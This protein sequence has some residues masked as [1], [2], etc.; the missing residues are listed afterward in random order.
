MVG[1]GLQEGGVAFLYIYFYIFVRGWIKQNSV[2][3]YV[4]GVTYKKGAAYKR[5]YS[6]Y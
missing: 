5:E 4:V 1:G 2:K 3:V 6:N